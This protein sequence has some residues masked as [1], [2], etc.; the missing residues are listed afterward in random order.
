MLFAFRIEGTVVFFLVDYSTQNVK[1][2]VCL[3]ELYIYV[4]PCGK[5]FAEG[6]NC[7]VGFRIAFDEGC[8]IGCNCHR[9]RM[10]CL[11]KSEHR[12]SKVAHLR[13]RR[14]FNT[15]GVCLYL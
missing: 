7:A 2:S 10:E 9:R 3:V 11:C 14:N 12:D 5:E 8:D 15:D 1:G 4:W 13:F 6:S